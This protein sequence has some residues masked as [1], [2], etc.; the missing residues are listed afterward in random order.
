MYPPPNPLPGG[1]VSCAVA[2][3]PREA[4]TLATV[5]SGPRWYGLSA[6]DADWVV[7]TVVMTAAAARPAVARSVTRRLRDPGRARP[8]PAP[9]GTGACIA[10]RCTART[11]L[12]D[13]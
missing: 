12:S 10:R 3:V 1:T 5:G 7:K 11:S 4:A 13:P 8:G 9:P 2:K 6:A